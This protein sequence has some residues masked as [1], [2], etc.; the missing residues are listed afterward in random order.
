LDLDVVNLGP[1]GHDAHGLCE[2]VHAPFA[3]ERLPQ[4]IG[5]IVTMTCEPSDD[6]EPVA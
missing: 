4:L 2:R 3:F 5:K 6:R 1:W